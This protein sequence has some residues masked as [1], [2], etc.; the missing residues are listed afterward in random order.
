MTNSLLLIIPPSM[1]MYPIILTE[2]HLKHHASNSFNL[3]KLYSMPVMPSAG[4]SLV[5][6][7]PHVPPLIALSI[8]RA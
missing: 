2:S 6:A 8:V 3:F 1:I 7:D 5:L 4:P